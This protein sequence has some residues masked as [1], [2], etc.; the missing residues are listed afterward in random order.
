[1][2]NTWITYFL[3]NDENRRMYAPSFLLIPTC[4]IYMSHTAIAFDVDGKSIFT[5]L[6]V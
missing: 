2:M 5:R 1:M 4:Q 6:Y 3:G